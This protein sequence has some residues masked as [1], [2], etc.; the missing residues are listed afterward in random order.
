MS[1]HRERKR[2]YGSLTPAH[3][4]IF[5]LNGSS[6]EREMCQSERLSWAVGEQ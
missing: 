6:T 5:I 3:Q 4:I 2:G 1:T